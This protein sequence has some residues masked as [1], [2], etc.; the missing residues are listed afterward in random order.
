LERARALDPGP[1]LER[2]E[3]WLSG[4]VVQSGDLTRIWEPSA[5][6]KNMLFR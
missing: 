2:V 3:A 1:D 5:F 6:E 4:T